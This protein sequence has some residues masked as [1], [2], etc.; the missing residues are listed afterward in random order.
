MAHLRKP[1]ST[2]LLGSTEDP[3]AAFSSFD[4]DVGDE[5]DPIDVGGGGGPPPPPP[6]LP[7]FATTT[8]GGFR[9][10]ARD[11]RFADEALGNQVLTLVNKFFQKA[12]A[13][14]GGSAFD[15][16]S[17]TRFGA[18]DLGSRTRVDLPFL[19]KLLD[20]GIPGGGD[21]IKRFLAQTAI[22]PEDPPKP[23]AP[24][25]PFDPSLPGAGGPTGRP[26]GGGGPPSGDGTSGGAGSSLHDIAQATSALGVD[27]LANTPP[28]LFNQIT[29]FDRA[30]D[31]SKIAEALFGIIGEGGRFNTDIL[32][33]RTELAREGL[34]R[35]RKSREASNRAALASRGILGEGGASGPE[36]TA[37]R[38]LEGDIADRFTNAFSGIFADESRNADLRLIQALS[39][40][41][42]LTS[43][44]SRQAIDSFR[45]FQ[46][47]QLG[48]GQLDL[49]QK[50]I[51]LRELLGTGRLDLDRDLGFG[52]LDLQRTLGLGNLALGNLAQ[53]NAF[54]LGS[55]NFGLDRDRFLA[56]QGN[57]DQDRIIQILRD[58]G[59]I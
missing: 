54:N 18:E 43:D 46:N 34:E 1:T 3:L 50:D 44:E 37:T 53:S 7:G 47:A 15:F 21:L 32:N 59:L 41:G 39:Q 36:L 13:D 40:T 27:P 33:R 38:R 56:G 9:G 11:P 30:F 19:N 49:G 14:P 57:I 35:Q 52:S 5:V 25:K 28:D 29:G 45:A 23:L 2:E 58:F 51:D 12:A 26:P 48:L 22:P 20:F 42:Q 16:L 55:A 8:V 31:P 10:G 4:P 24:A 6:I 17:G